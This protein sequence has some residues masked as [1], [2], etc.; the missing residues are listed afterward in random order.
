MHAAET[1][2]AGRSR[3][4]FPLIITKKLG[5][6][7]RSKAAVVRPKAIPG[8]FGSFSATIPRVMGI[9]ILKRTIPI[10]ETTI[11]PLPKIM[12]GREARR[13]IIQ[14]GISVDNEKISDD[15]KELLELCKNKNAIVIINKTDK[16]KALSREDVKALV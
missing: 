9:V 15:D 14:N 4:I 16:E 1:R 6:A 10:T 3:N 8:F 12:N 11:F 7:P 5:T 13:L 2:T